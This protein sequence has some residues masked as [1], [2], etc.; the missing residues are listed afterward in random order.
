MPHSPPEKFSWPNPRL[1]SILGI[2]MRTIEE[3][4]YSVKVRR[5]MHQ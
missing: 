2:L 5:D 4:G 1:S 3:I